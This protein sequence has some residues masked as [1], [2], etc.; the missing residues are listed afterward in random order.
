[1]IIE[2]I[3][4]SQLEDKECVCVHDKHISCDILQHCRDNIDYQDIKRL[5]YI[6]ILLLSHSPR[7]QSIDCV[8][9]SYQA[10]SLHIG[11]QS[12]TCKIQLQVNNSHQANMH[13]DGSCLLRYWI[14][15]FPVMRKKPHKYTNTNLHHRLTKCSVV[16]WQ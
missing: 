5:S 15:M 11:R 3:D 12:F 8:Q 14:L 9:Y 1:M 16:L 4:Q 7:I 2:I 6:E 13:Q 10:N